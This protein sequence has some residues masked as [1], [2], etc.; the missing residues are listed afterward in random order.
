V[1]SYG[2][3][4]PAGTPNREVFT[5]IYDEVSHLAACPV[6]ARMIPTRDD[7][8]TMETHYDQ[9]GYSTTDCPG[10]S[11]YNGR[12]AAG[13]TTAETIAAGGDRAGTGYAARHSD[14]TVNV[15]YAEHKHH[16][17]K[18]AWAQ[19]MEHRIMSALDDVTKDLADAQAAIALIPGL[20]Q[21]VTDLQSAIT[22][23]PNAVP[24]SVLAAAQALETASV[25]AQSAV[26]NIPTPAT[27]ADPAHPAVPNNPAPAGTTPATDPN[28]PPAQT[29]PT[30]APADPNAPA[31]PA[32]VSTPSPSAPSGG[33]PVVDPNVPAA[34]PAADTPI[35]SGPPA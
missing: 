3:Y 6:C 19:E 30:S 21:K 1:T 13:T 25:D 16:P 9:R 20:A 5:P 4:D 18:P 17:D 26:K 10:T 11:R 31:A 35:Q 22:A 29:P 34:P 32:A 12:H 8:G 14:F 24:A 27:P 23:D 7:D 33:G 28:A 15:T 2:G